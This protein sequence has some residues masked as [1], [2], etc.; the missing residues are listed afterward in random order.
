MGIKLRYEEVEVAVHRVLTTEV[1]LI[2]YAGIVPEGLL[3]EVARAAEKLSGLRVVHVNATPIGGGVA[4][5]L[6]SLVPLMRSVGIDAE[7]YAIEPDESFFRVGKALHHCLQGDS[8]DLGGDEMALYPAHNEG[9]AR[10][11]VAMGVNADI[12]IVHDV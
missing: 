7:W 2:S 8:T 1:K 10:A 6:K 12:W 9:A 3:A 4:E 5:I 11:L